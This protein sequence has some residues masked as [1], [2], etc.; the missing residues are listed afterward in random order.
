MSS[1]LDGKGRGYRAGVNADNRLETFAISESRVADVSKTGYSFLVATG[2]VSLTTTGSY[3][4]LVYIKNNST[5]RDIFI[6]TVRTCSTDT[7]SI[8]LKLYRNPTTGTLISDANPADQFSAN[9]ASSVVF[10]GLAYSASGDGK[11]VTDGDNWTQFINRSPGHSIQDY[12]GAIVI[13]GGKSMALA[14]KPSVSTTICVEIQLWF[15]E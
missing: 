5:R 7:G 12:D 1:I 13:P 11:T 14:A 4:G 9:A 15:E 2:F 3:N 6:K 8:Q 10:D